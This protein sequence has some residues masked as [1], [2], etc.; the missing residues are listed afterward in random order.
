MLHYIK[1]SKEEFPLKLKISESLP[2]NFDPKTK[3]GDHTTLIWE[4]H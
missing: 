4:D 2:D 3:I 1:N